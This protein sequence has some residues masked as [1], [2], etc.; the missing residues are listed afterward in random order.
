MRA[1][2]LPGGTSRKNLIVY[3]ISLISV[4]GVLISLN[5]GGLK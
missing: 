5:F 2:L 1:L 3:R 4:S